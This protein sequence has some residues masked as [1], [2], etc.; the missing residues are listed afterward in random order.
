M[1]CTAILLAGSRPGGDPLAAQFGVALKALI[2]VGGVP[3]V[4]RVAEALL[5]SPRV[6]RLLVLA[7]DPQPI[8]AVLPAHPDLELRRSAATIARSLLD[9][10]QDEALA[11]PLLVTTADHALLDGAMI[12]QFCDGASG[13]DLAIGVV[14]RGTVL[15]RFPAA[16]RTWL[17]FRGGAF[18]GANLFLL[19][20][21]RAVPAIRAW[22]GVEQ[23]RKNAARLLW[24]LGPALF[25]GAVLR[26]RSLE[27]TLGRAGRALGLD[28]RAVRMTDA[29]AAV[30]ID[31]ADDHRLAETVLGKR[32]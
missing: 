19:G 28:A 4:R 5:A 27:S 32:A 12:E 24:T 29:L 9:L 16:R 3:M 11:W 26:L 31:K 22:Q 18:S 25:L 21:P 1:R 13:A 7:Q 8:A 14:E 2:P 23:D 20:G 15:A 17:R 10:A 6:G 30:D